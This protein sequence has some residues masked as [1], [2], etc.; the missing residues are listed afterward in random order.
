MRFPLA[1]TLALSLIACASSRPMQDATATTD[2][3]GKSKPNLA[4]NAGGPNAKGKYTCDYEE[5]TGSHLRQ[6]I[7]RYVDSD[8]DARGR[9]QD[10]IRE[11]EQHML[12]PMKGN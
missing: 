4:S 1:A 11:F 2:S 10:D 3:S 5:D 8:N 9:V 6:K 12:A 7:C